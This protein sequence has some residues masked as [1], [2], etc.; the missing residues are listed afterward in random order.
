[1]NPTIK[2]YYSR[3]VVKATITKNPIINKTVIS[4]IRQGKRYTI[5]VVYDNDAHVIRFGLAVCSPLDNF[6]K[7]I[8]KDIATKR[9]MNDPFYIIYNFSGVRN[10][11]HTE[12]RQ[13][14][15]DTEYTLMKKD[16]PGIFNKDM[17]L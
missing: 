6:C 14:V 11:Y 8:G 4:N 1:M 7:S 3:P 10:N 9:A 12:V 16:N 5:A 2:F 13:I 17:I 15:T